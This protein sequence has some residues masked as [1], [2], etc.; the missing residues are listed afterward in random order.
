L[1]ILGFN[2]FMH[3]AAATLLQDGRIVCAV[4][5]ERFARKKHV[6]DF[7]LQAIRCAL[8]AGGIHA[9]E[10]DH[11]TFFYKPWLGVGRRVLHALKNLPHAAD[12]LERRGGGWLKF[13]NAEQ[14]F[15]T[16]LGLAGEEGPKFHF[17]EHHLAHA[18]STFFGSRFDE[19]AILSVDGAGEW[20]TT[21][22]AQGSGRK[23]RKLG[24]VYYPHSLGNVYSAFTQYLGF[25]P[26]SGEGKVMGLAPYGDPSRFIDEFRRIIRLI[27][28][29]AFEI[30][31]AYFQHHLG[32]ERRYGDRVIESFGPAREP[33]SPMQKVYEDVAAALQ[34]RLE[35]AILHLARGLQRRTGLKRLCMA[36]GVAL[37]SVANGR[38]LHET[39]FEEIFIQPAASDD[40]TS[41]GGAY[42][43][44]T[45]VLGGDRPA[46]MRHASLGPEF[47]DA[48]CRA[49]IAAA[50]LHGESTD[51]VPRAA[52]LLANGKIVGW[53]HGRAEFGPR[54]LGNRSILTDPRPAAMKDVLNA[55]VKRRE[56]FRPFAPAVL[57]ERRD[58]YFD[59]GYESPFMLLVENVRAAKRGELGAVTH[60]DGTARVQ[61]VERDCNPRFYD[62]IAEF[63]RLTGTPV[64]LN[65]S[66]NV[67]GEPIVNTPAEA[68]RGYLDMD[69]DALVLGDRLLCKENGSRGGC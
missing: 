28:E 12:L 32:K 66:F 10:L 6:G 48:V 36:G 41:L 8:E 52:Q 40:G 18:A 20:A 59:G 54:A 58:E 16:E 69:M 44:W 35:E 31:L 67:R 33:E 30:D 24:E 60:V 56:G 57:V 22:F 5:E 65:T 26:N 13:R 29:G 51:V 39:D 19:A 1:N 21:L 63:G 45:C 42:F 3:D 53:F 50:G 61:D 4:A 9:R 38:I 25:R 49:A 46:P 11:V 55:R 7:P 37:N 62:L 23:I 17:L 47:S 34:L 15:R 14:T 2:C 27:P 43:L 64:L 68:I